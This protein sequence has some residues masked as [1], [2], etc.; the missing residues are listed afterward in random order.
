MK[1]ESPALRQA[2]ARAMGNLGEV[3]T[4]VAEG[5]MLQLLGAKDEDEEN[6]LI[7]IKDADEHV[8]RAAG[9]SVG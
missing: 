4:D 7:G 6:E 1:D 9:E 8:R 5:L 2:A 3:S